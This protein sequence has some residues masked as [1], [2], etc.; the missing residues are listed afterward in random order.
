MDA[1][2]EGVTNQA[3]PAS[4]RKADSTFPSSE[5]HL[6]AGKSQEKIE[7]NQHHQFTPR[8]S[9]N[10]AH[11]SY[12]EKRVHLTASRRRLLTSPL[13]T[14]HILVLPADSHEVCGLVSDAA[15]RESA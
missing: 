4:S 14:L 3:C 1:I 5:T 12:H 8:G 2:D 10:T 6:A 15:E 13:P 7:N 9:F 11:L